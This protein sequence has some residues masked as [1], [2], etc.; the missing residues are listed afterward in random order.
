MGKLPNHV[1]TVLCVWLFF[2]GMCFLYFLFLTGREFRVNSLKMEMKLCDFFERVTFP[3]W[4][5]FK[6]FSSCNWRQSSLSNANWQFHSIPEKWLQL[7]NYST[8]ALILFA[9][10]AP[11]G[12][13][14][15]SHMLCYFLKSRM[16]NMV[17]IMSSIQPSP[18]TL[19]PQIFQLGFESYHTDLT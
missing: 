12:W 1:N 4:D 15:V 19:G 11:K 13:S 16:S 14:S 7:T 9:H 5:L 2:F 17:Q 18:I 8:I 3:N 10:V 6:G